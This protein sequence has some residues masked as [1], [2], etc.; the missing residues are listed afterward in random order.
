MTIFAGNRKGIEMNIAVPFLANGD[1]FEVI[2]LISVVE[3][4]ARVH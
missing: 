3:D 2:S 4:V 1:D